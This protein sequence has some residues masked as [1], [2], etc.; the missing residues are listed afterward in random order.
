MKKYVLRRLAGAVPL[1]LG[2]ATIVFFLTSLAPG[3]P[4]DFVIAPGVTQEVREQ[5]RANYGLDD[6]IPV[7]YV[8]WVGQA[9]RGNLGHS[10]TYSRPV[11]DVVGE[12]L[13][14]TLILSGTALILSFLIGIVVGTIQADRQYSI[15]DSSM[16]VVLLFFYSM[17]SFWL[18]LMLIMTMSLFA[19]NVWDLPI[20][21]PA[22]GMESVNNPQMSPIQAFLDRLWHLALPALSLSLV[23][24]AGIARYMRTSMLEVIR[25]DY[26]RT[27]MAKGLSREVVVFKHALRNAL[28]PIITL[29]GLY[30]PFLFSGTVFIEYVF[31]WPGMGRALVDAA[32]QRDYSLVMGGSLFFATIVVVANL[33]ADLLYAVI[34]PRIRYD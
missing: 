29:V 32:L 13:P 1:V 8:K 27:A 34:D 25:Q 4:A 20:W 3:D 19:R 28:L 26:V 16:S 17:P 22:S 24:T 33:V 5:L 14:N 7:R 9:A 11:I 21:F 6:P 18:S 30:L 15:F 12:F 31:A 2:I 23:L 10:L